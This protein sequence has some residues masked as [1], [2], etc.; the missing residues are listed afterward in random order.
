MSCNINTFD[1]DVL[2]TAGMSEEDIAHSVKISEKTLE[3]AL[4]IGGNAIDLELVG[5]AD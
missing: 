5:G 3:I 2:R 1:I 4:R